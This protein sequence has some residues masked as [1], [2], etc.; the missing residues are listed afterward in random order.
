MAARLRLSPHYAALARL[1][2]SDDDNKLSL[3]VDAKAS[4]EIAAICRHLDLSCEVLPAPP[5][6]SASK[7]ITVTRTD[8][9]FDE[10]PKMCFSSLRVAL[11]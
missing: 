10:V 9:A 4:E 1:A 8:N 7:R 5:G 2:A 3:D 11:F 6:S